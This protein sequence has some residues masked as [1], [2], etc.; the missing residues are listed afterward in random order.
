MVARADRDALT[1]MSVGRTAARPSDMA[2]L[3]RPAI[4]LLEELSRGG[5][6]AW[7]DAEAHDRLVLIELERERLV[8]TRLFPPPGPRPPAWARRRKG[9][10]RPRRTEVRVTGAGALRLQRLREGRRSA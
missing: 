6:G 5:S 3:S 7:L 8:E 10:D 1:E 9:A 2:L 4:Q